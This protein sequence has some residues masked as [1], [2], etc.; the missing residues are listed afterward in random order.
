MKRIVLL[1]AAVSVLF[2][3]SVLLAQGI[4][5]T[6]GSYQDKFR[7]LDEV[8][9][10][11]NVYRNASGQPRHQYWQQEVDYEIEVALDEDAQR[12]E[13]TETI[14][15]QNNSPDSLGYLW[16]QLDQNRFRNDSIGNLSATFNGSSPET[17]SPARISLGQLRTIQY[18]SD[19]DLGYEINSVRDSSGND[20]A[21]TIVGTLMRVDLAR[22]LNSGQDI[23]F[24]IDYAYNV[25]NGDV[26][27]RKS[28]V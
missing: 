12:I 22:P 2:S 6:K 23:E 5:Q 7:Q 21:H 3:S 8:L 27:D 28:V 13:G 16:L 4:Q 18:N 19:A 14:R 25:V 9:P 15:Y 26:L 24:E 1:I 11:P 20:L 17:D 10:T